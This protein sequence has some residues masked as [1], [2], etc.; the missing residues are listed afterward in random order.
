[1]TRPLRLLLLCLLAVAG[2]AFSACGDDKAA[3]RTVGETE[4]FLLDVSGL[5]YQVQIS[6]YLNPADVE[7]AQYLQGLPEGVRPT[8][9]QTWFAVFLRVQNTSSE[10][11][12]MAREYEIEDTLG[13]TYR[14]V[15]LDRNANSFV[16]QPREL[17]PGN[18]EPHPDSA[19]G[20]GPIQ[21]SLL[22]FR[23]DYESTQ[24]RPLEF[25]IVSPENPD[26]VATVSLDV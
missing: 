13:K 23:I 12:A 25:R 16:F 21:G 4:A 26:E 9:D 11:H 6:R 20:Q 17:R 22:L 3:L 19:A 2:T 15:P 5:R 7:D 1:M 14:P 18:L 24:N 8:K 10:T